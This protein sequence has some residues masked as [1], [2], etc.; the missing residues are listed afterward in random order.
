MKTRMIK[1]FIALFLPIILHQSLQASPIVV[2]SGNLT[3]RLIQVDLTKAQSSQ[4]QICWH[5]KIKP[6]SGIVVS[7]HFRHNPV[8]LQ[9]M[10]H[11]TIIHGHITESI[12]WN[13]TPKTQYL[14]SFMAK[15]IN[16]DTLTFSSNLM[17]ADLIA[18]Q[19]TFN[20]SEIRKLDLF[21]Y[22]TPAPQGF[23]LKDS[24][25]FSLDIFTFAQV[26]PEPTTIILLTLCS[27]I[28]LTKFKKVQQ[29][30]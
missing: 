2:D 30:S 28:F 23:S 7:N 9:N 13:L 21:T 14:L 26:T 20:F 5:Q 6:E 29:S 22:R 17:A 27:I 16:I 4:E 10:L 8:K 3:R 11:E 25:A 12:N 24:H 19:S 18:N 1:L 15:H